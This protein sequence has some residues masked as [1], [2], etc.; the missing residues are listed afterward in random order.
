MHSL[1]LLSLSE[2]T[3]YA[4]LYRHIYEASAVS[5][6]FEGSPYILTKQF[7]HKSDNNDKKKTCYERQCVFGGGSCEIKEAIVRKL[8]KSNLHSN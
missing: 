1:I 6:I 2:V 3:D 7:Y 8:N 4:Y 5:L